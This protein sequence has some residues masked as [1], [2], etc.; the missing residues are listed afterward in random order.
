MMDIALV[1]CVCAFS[2]ELGEKAETFL[3]LHCLRF[4][5]FQTRVS[6]FI[7]SELMISFELWISHV[8]IVKVIAI[9]RDSKVII[10][11]LSD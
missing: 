11:I 1:L 3:A 2:V 6:E 8:V 10:C 9:E 4:R 7:A 5:Y